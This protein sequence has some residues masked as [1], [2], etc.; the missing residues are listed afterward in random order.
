M[1]AARDLTGQT[2]GRWTVLRS[3]G[4]DGNRKDLWEC[5]CSCAAQTVKVV[6]GQELRRGSSLSCGCLRAE[7]L[8]ERNRQLLGTGRTPEEQ[9]QIDLASKRRPRKPCSCKW[10]GDKI[11]A[12]RTNQV[13]CSGECAWEYLL[14]LQRSRGPERRAKMTTAERGR[15][16]AYIREWKRLRA[17]DQLVTVAA[18]L[19]E[20]ARD[21]QC[22]DRI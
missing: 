17:L 3:S 19:T 22:I 15:R 21:V 7:Q 16:A 11:A 12:P 14:S 1:P 5:R 9:Y 20:R 4:R 6:R 10:C 8:A 18:E 13:H 2:F